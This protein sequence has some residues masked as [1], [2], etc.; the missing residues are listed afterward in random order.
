MA[1]FDP[2]RYARPLPKQGTRTFTDPRY[3]ELELTLTFRSPDIVDISTM[4]D[5]ANGFVSYYSDKPFPAVDGKIVTVGK[6]LAESVASLFVLQEGP[7]EDKFTMEEWVAM[8]VTLPTII[9]DINSFVAELTE[10]S[11]LGNLVVTHKSQKSSQ[12]TQKDTQP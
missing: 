1:K 2:F 7:P 9:A 3:P 4:Q 6:A 11:D 8:S 10:Q 12:D 5:V